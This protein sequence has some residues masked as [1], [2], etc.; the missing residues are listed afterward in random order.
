MQVDNTNIM[1]EEF[2]EVEP[3]LKDINLFSNSL[4]VRIKIKI[5]N[6]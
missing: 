2:I 5:Y 6:C 4:K 1:Y 3:D